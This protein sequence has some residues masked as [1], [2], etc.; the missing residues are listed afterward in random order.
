MK[1]LEDIIAAHQGSF[2][3]TITSSESGGKTVALFPAYYKTLGISSA[4]TLAQTLNYAS[5]TELQT[6]QGSGIDA[7]L[8]DGSIS[9][10]TV[11]VA[12]KNANTSVRMFLDFIKS[13]K[14]WIKRLTISDSTAGYLASIASENLYYGYVSP[15]IKGA[16]Y[17][18]DLNPFLYTSQNITTKMIVDLR[19]YK[20]IANDMLLMYLALPTTHVSTFM[21]ELGTM[22]E[23]MAY[24]G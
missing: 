10:T 3:Y 9:T 21:W 2:G 13:K 6:A 18:I 17:N 22:E 14:L 7:V 5:V 12:A 8:D 19:P 11:S 24:S 23:L 20:I 1:A 4:T 15:L 16:I